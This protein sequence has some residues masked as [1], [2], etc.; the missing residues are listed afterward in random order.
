MM[1]LYLLK[2]ISR[3]GNNISQS[4]TKIE[5]DETLIKYERGNEANFS[6]LILCRECFKEGKESRQNTQRTSVPFQ[7]EYYNVYLFSQK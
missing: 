1:I 3:H 2:V 5:L 4:L 6:V 7:T